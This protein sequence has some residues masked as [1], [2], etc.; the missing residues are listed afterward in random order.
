MSGRDVRKEVKERRNRKRCIKTVC[1]LRERKESAS[2]KAQNWTQKCEE[3][4]GG[5]KKKGG[6][7]WRCLR[8]RRDACL[9]KRGVERARQAFKKRLKK[10]LKE[11]A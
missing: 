9:G 4:G 8:M 1:S 6:W 2:W 5:E 7:N 3:K 11:C 10:A